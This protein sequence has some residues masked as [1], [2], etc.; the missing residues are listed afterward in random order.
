MFSCHRRFWFRRLWYIKTIQLTGKQ[1]PLQQEKDSN[2]VNIQRM[3][4]GFRRED[5]PSVPQIAVPI[6]VPNH[7]ME[8]G[9]E[10]SSPKQQAVGCLVLIAFY[11]LLRV[12]EYTKPQYVTRNGILPHVHSQIAHRTQPLSQWHIVTRHIVTMGHGT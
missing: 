4:E 2:Q 3:L 9:M 8:K 10:S 12:G 6:S 1:S 11:Y 5:P 7:C